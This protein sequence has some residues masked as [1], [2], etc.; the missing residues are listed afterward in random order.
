LALDDCDE[1]N[2]CMQVVPGSHKWPILCAK[3][4][5]ANS[6]FTNIT[7]PLPR[8]TQ[9]VPVL[10]KAGDVL[11][12]GGA[13]VHGSFPN[14]SPTRFRRSLIGH[15]VEGQTTELTRFDQPV[16]RM[17]GEELFLNFSAGGGP[18]GVW[19]E[20][21]GTPQVEMSGQLPGSGASA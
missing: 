21:N 1:E 15:Y 7:T 12:F 19:T 18:C 17:D 8:N 14:T 4:A 13:L 5:D 16:L 6:S 2:G 11:F 3:E 9:S 10:M 20:Q